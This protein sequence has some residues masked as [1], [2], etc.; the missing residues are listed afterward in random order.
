MTTPIYPVRQKPVPTLDDVLK[1][2][3][4]VEHHYEPRD[5]DI[6]ERL[7]FCRFLNSHQLQR[8]FFTNQRTAQIRLS[9][10]YERGF[11]D[12]FRPP[13]ARGQGSNPYIYTLD[14]LGYR[15]LRH[16]RPELVG[17][18]YWREKTPEFSRVIHDV[19]LN[20]FCLNFLDEAPRHGI[21][22]LLWLTTKQAV[23]RIDVDGRKAMYAPDAILTY[24]VQY[25]DATNP[26]VLHIEWER[27]ADRRWFL[28]KLQTWRAYRQA[29]RW[30]AKGY[31]A[32]P[33]I[34]VVGRRREAG[35]LGMYSIEP[36]RLAAAREKF[37]EIFFLYREDLQAGKW[38]LLN[39]QGGR[40]SLWDLRSR[41]VW[42]DLVPGG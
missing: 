24:D 12:R 21:D 36:L 16:L 11:V 27:S 18:W 1:E 28:E 26:V 37:S 35:K 22:N 23:Q 17:R 31:R 25:E 2:P 6:M 19:E 38:H 33:K 34:I 39:P 10:L 4:R 14:S 20:D 5:V 15:L 13:S 40:I 8:L 3:Q 42:D 30:Q 41:T 32:E 29:Q 7:Y 9:K